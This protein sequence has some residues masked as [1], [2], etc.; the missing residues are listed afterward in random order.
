MPNKGDVIKSSQFV[1]NTGGTYTGAVTFNGGATIGSGQTLTNSGT[2]SGGTISNVSTISTTGTVTVGG[3]VQVTNNGSA[4]QWSNGSSTVSKLFDNG[5]LNIWTDDQTYFGSA[6]T[7]STAIWEW[8]SGASNS[9]GA[10][11]T[12]TVMMHLDGTG[13]LSTKSNNI[14]DDGSGNVTVVGGTVKLTNATTNIIR[15]GN[16]G[17]APPAASGTISAGMKLLLWDDG[18]YQYGGI[19]IDSGTTW[20]S[21]GSYHKWYGYANATA[22]TAPTLLATLDNLGNLT[23]TGNLTVSGTGSSTISGNLTV[24]GLSLTSGNGVTINGGVFNYNAPNT[25]GGWARGFNYQASDASSVYA[26]IGLYGTSTTLNNLYLGFG[27]SAWSNSGST[28]GLWITPAGAVTTKKNT[29]DDGS[30][31]AT[32]AG[33]ITVNGSGTNVLNGTTQLNGALYFKAV[34]DNTDSTYIT[35]TNIASDLTTLD[36]VVGDNGVGTP[37]T[38]P[39]TGTTDYLAVKNTGGSIY[40]MFGTDGSAQHSGSLTVGG[41]TT[42]NGILNINSADYNFKSTTNGTTVWQVQNSSGTAIVNID[43]TNGRMGINNTAPTQA[44]DVTGAGHFSSNLQ[45]DGK[46]LAA[47]GSGTAG[48]YSFTNDGSQD[49]G[50]FSPS[51]GILDFYSNGQKT[52]EVNTV[53]VIPQKSVAITSG[54]GL[55]Y[56][57]WGATGAFASYSIFMS[58]SSTSGAGKLDSTSDYNMYLRMSG[59]TNRGFVFQ[60]GSGNVA[61]I[62]GGGNAYFNGTVNSKTSIYPTLGSLAQGSSVYGGQVVNNNTPYDRYPSGISL[63]GT[64]G[65]GNSG[66]G[67]TYGIVETYTGYGDS[68]AFPTQM[69]YGVDG[70]VSTRTAIM[71]AKP[72]WTGSATHSVNDY[73]MPTSAHETGHYY[74]ATIAGTSTGTEPTWPTTS[75]A[76][77]QDSAGTTTWA[78]STAY[79]LNALVVP[80]TSN[81]YYYK[82]TTAGTSGSAAPTWP[83]TSGS[84]VTDGTAVWTAYGIITW[85]EVG[86]FWGSFGTLSRT[87]TG[88]TWSQAQ[89][90]SSGITATGSNTSK[91]GTIGTGH[92]NEMW[93]LSG[94]SGTGSLYINYRSYDETTNNYMNTMIANGKGSTALTITG[95]TSAVTTS[96]NTLDDGSGKATF[97]GQI[98]A[99]GGITTPS[100]INFTGTNGVSKIVYPNAWAGL[101]L[102]TGTNARHINMVTAA[103]VTTPRLIWDVEDTTNWAHQMELYSN[104]TLKLLNSSGSFTNAGTTTLSGALTVNAATTLNGT[105]TLNNNTISGITYLYG[106]YGTIAKSVDEWLRLNDDGSHSSGVYFGSSITRTDGQFQVGNAGQYFKVD[107]A[108]NTTVAGLLTMASAGYQD[109]GLFIPFPKGGSYST[110]TTTVTGAIKVVLPVGYTNTMMRFAVDIYEYST[111][112]SFTVYVGGYNYSTTPGWVNPTAYIV[113]NNVNRDF[114]VRFGYDGSAHAIIYI[115]ELASTWSYPQVTVRD[116][117]A[118]YGGNTLSSWSSGW[119]IG[120]ETSAFTNVTQTVSSAMVVA[121]YAQN[122]DKLDGID[123]TGFMQSTN[124]NGY[125]GITGPNAGTSNWIRT[126]TNGII[127]YQSGSSSALGTSSWRF[128]SIYGSLGDFSGNL[129]VAGT[130]TFSG[131]LK[132]ND[133]ISVGELGTT[134]ESAVIS[135]AAAVSQ[136]FSGSAIGDTIIRNSTNTSILLGFN[137]ASG[138]ESPALKVSYNGAANSAIVA[139][140]RNTLDN[141]AGNMSV[142]GTLTVTGAT[143]LNG[144]LTVPNTINVANSSGDLIYE[145]NGKTV[146]GSFPGWNANMLYLNLYSNGGNQTQTFSSGVQITGN[147]TVTGVLTVNST[148]TLT[149]A[150]TLSS[151]LGVTGATTLSSTL[152]VTGNTTLS[153]TAT[154]S[155]ATTINNTLNVTNAT[156]SSWIGGVRFIQSGTTNYIESFTTNGGSTSATLKLTGA[157]GAAANISTVNNTLDDG[158]GNMSVAGTLTVT[159]TTTLNGVVNINSA[160]V[161]FKSTTN[162]TSAFQVQNSAGTGIFNIDTTNT[163]VGINNNAPA[164]TLDLNGTLN[165]TGATTLNSSLSITKVGGQML[166]LNQSD[167]ASGTYNYIGFNDNTGSWKSYIGWSSSKDNIFRMVNSI[168]DILINPTAAGSTIQLSGPSTIVKTTTNGVSAFQV[169]NSSASTVLDVDTTNSRVGIATANPAYTLDVN[170]TF[171]AQSSATFTNGLTSSTDINLAAVGTATSGG[172]SSNG[173]MFNNSVW[174][175]TSAVTHQRKIFLT[176]GDDIWITNTS[177]TQ[178]F[179]LNNNGTLTLATGLM[180]SSVNIYSSTSTT[181]QMVIG[182]ATDLNSSSTKYATYGFFDGDAYFQAYTGGPSPGNIS[183]IIDGFVDLNIYAQDAINI[184]PG[185]SVSIGAPSVTIGSSAT[186]SANIYMVDD[187]GLYNQDMIRIF[188]KGNNA[189]A[190]KSVIYMDGNANYNNSVLWYSSG[191][192]DATSIGNNLLGGT[193]ITPNG[194]GQ[195]LYI[196]N[197][198]KATIQTLKMSTAAGAGG[199]YTFQYWNGTS[200]LA[201]PGLYDGSNGFTSSNSSI[202]NISW[203]APSDWAAVAPSWTT[204]WSPSTG[205]AAPS[206]VNPGGFSTAAQYWIRIGCTTAPAS[207]GYLD[208]ISPTPMSLSNLINLSYAGVAMFKVDNYGSVSGINGNFIQVVASG[209]NSNGNYLQYDDGT[210]ICWKTW[211]SASTSGQWSGSVSYPN[212]TTGLYYMHISNTWVFPMA[213]NTAPTVT[214]TGDFSGVF[215]EAHSA[216]SPSTTQCS[217]EDGI[218]STSGPDT[219]GTAVSRNCIAVGRW[220]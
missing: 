42:L 103:D 139:T 20:Y 182:A 17:M 176:G 14:L 124:A 213:F 131:I 134:T 180:T 2:I 53:G 115:G 12:G 40:H 5:Q 113:G 21:T 128:A 59:G 4:F 199:A 202:V 200:W 210:Q 33:T 149:G 56:N 166:S 191:W 18:A 193:Q 7:G 32:F 144:N 132:A 9:T 16:V 140:Q 25:G 174:N 47:E 119:S 141:G 194:S 1:L 198:N 63:M 37:L 120:F 152:S 107:A 15:M 46:F 172:L 98:T 173:V 109:N 69:V 51:D 6:G 65:A 185:N 92:G 104:G 195:Y 211:P 183:G 50:M 8:K 55:G 29:V 161:N 99:T 217:I 181:A 162:G 192:S 123:S 126:T 64:T 138:S 77:V 67:P 27:T 148:T 83:V 197:V 62:D 157:N 220:K 13:K 26:G 153:G 49:T 156:S 218:F 94:S 75:G 41:T 58:A 203:N 207:Y 159:G 73:I 206:A 76:T 147:T 19:G 188:R 175:G 208:Y 102:T 146:L 101:D 133:S 196:G 204:A 44:L 205:A 145:I 122:A 127:P 130:A 125:D 100:T 96:H 184:S 57:F 121:S 165:V 30:G 23:N 80:T 72:V 129:N 86:T 70:S 60:N 212:P 169:Q 189:M 219:S 95:S 143:N 106:Q 136:Y 82:C 36:I 38:A 171:R 35:K 209:S 31:N 142:A 66:F 135:G 111:G 84:T 114:T 105:L 112:K 11:S 186:T 52:L 3:S 116:F 87:D 168:G 164:Y 48:G 89:T 10:Q 28:A 155:G 179:D 78:A 216:F 90:F 160:D 45:V 34:S 97:A 151:T 24:S 91:I 54:D 22:G 74:Q 110:T 61:Q 214:S 187:E 154:I 190:S 71:G 137:G 201:L 118:G 79:A 85:K 81:G 68:S 117:Y 178:V 39:T 93:G 167:Y 88:Y 158:S 150:A 108:G 170:G 215:Q 163:R 177:G 43:T